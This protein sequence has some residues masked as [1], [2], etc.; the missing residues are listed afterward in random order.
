[1]DE[2]P[3]KVLVV[4]G[5]AREHAIAW[6]LAASHRR[7]SLIIAPGNAGSARLGVNAAVDAEDVDGLLELARAESAELTVV[8]PEVPLALGIVDRFEKAGLPIYGPTQAAARIESDKWFAKTAMVESGVP[9][10]AATVCRDYES[11]LRFVERGEPP[12]VVKAN[13]LAAGKGVSIAQDRAAARAALRLM[14]EERAF[15]SAGDSVV[16]EELLEGREVSAFAFL[17]GG[18]V[19][20]IAA[21][22]DYKR[23]RDGDLGPNTG[24]M[25]S[26][27]PPP[28]WDAELAETV[29]KRI[30]QPIADYL[31]RAGCPFRGTLYAGLMLTPNDGPMV[32]E[33]NCRLGDPE[34]QVVLPRLETDL[35]DIMLATVEG[36]LSEVRASWSDDK[37]VGVVMASG[38]Y[39]GA[40]ETG[41]EIRGLPSPA[42]DGVVFHAGTRRDGA[43]IATDGGRVLT[44]TAR[45]DSLA[46]ARR[47]AYRIAEGI[48]FDNAYYRRD[49][50]QS[51]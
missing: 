46:D 22:C 18:Y 15:G 2:R 42:E 38:G 27:S 41:A 45:G 36:R 21:A 33:F 44:A 17:D 3:M 40:Y 4:G 39:P 7:P 31:V 25:G 35:L 11:A 29:R 10:A 48:E 14:F 19:S 51:V 47:R 43:K 13:G 8:G 28:F 49:I 37:W 50:A 12:F 23:I 1:M 5:G 34:A 16:F 9:T 30:M 26:Y 20:E 24:G 32:I 6:R